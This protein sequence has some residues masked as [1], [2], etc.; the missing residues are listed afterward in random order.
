MTR[1]L[2]K[3]SRE[4]ELFD[5]A[6][7]SLLQSI[8]QRLLSFY[9]TSIG[10]Y[11]SDFVIDDDKLNQISEAHILPAPQR[12]QL[13]FTHCDQ[14]MDIAIYVSDYLK[15]ELIST[16]PLTQLTHHN[17]DAFCVLIEEISHFHLLTQ[18]ATEQIPVSQLELEW[19][20][21][22]DKFLICSGLLFEQTADPHYLPLA[23]KLFDHARFPASP[24]QQRYIAAN[25]L[26]AFFCY[27][28]IDNASF[29]SAHPEDSI[30]RSV[31]RSTYLKSWLTKWE[32]T[33]RAL[34]RSAA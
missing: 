15:E 9:G 1:E 10:L 22:M 7:L 12:A 23:R 2:T 25:D 8:E 20:A 4:I 31:L 24:D 34:C 33:N 19:Q 17:L 14:Q 32:S 21:E 18:K 29:T 28:F 11:A 3:N 5:C 13:L 30:L 27:R 16:S 6:W 26:A